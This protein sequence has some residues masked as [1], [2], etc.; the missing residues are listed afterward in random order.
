MVGPRAAE[1]NVLRE[2]DGERFVLVSKAAIFL[3]I[4][5]GKKEKSEQCD[6]L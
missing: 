2:T 5:T 1:W 6:Q 3:E 4:C